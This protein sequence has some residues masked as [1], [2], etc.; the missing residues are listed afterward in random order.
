MRLRGHKPI[1]GEIPPVV[2]N[3]LATYNAERARGIVHTEDWK[4]QMAELQS[5]FDRQYVADSAMRG[6]ASQA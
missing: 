4:K 3:K 1:L 5:V 6:I 2:L